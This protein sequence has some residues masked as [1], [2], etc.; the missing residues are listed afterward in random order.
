MN[1][2]T[3]ATPVAASTKTTGRSESHAKR[4]HPNDQRLGQAVDANGVRRSTRESVSTVMRINGETVLRKN[5]YVV[6]GTGYEFGAFEEDSKVKVKKSSNDATRKQKGTTPPLAKKPRREDPS[7]AM[8]SLH[9]DQVKA[10]IVQKHVLREAFLARHVDLL[11]PFLEQHKEEWSHRSSKPS[12]LKTLL[13][14]HQEQQ[15]PQQQKQFYQ[16]KQ[17]LVQP[18]LLEGHN[19]VMRD[20]QMLGLQFMVNMHHQNLGMIL[21]DEMGLVRTEFRG[22]FASHSVRLS[23]NWTL[24]Y[25][26]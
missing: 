15:E 1:N 5:N 12:I 2:G 6:K 16:P 22:N 7:Q 4:D 11:K 21:G 25:K 13:R 14:V 18:D 9:N 17:I 10:Q 8:R 26:N 24:V 20:Y 23:I 19:V 3:V